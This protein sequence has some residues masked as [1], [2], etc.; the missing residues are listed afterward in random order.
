MFLICTVPVEHFQSHKELFVLPLFNFF[1]CFRILHS[2]S[3]YRSSDSEGHFDTPEEATPV[4]S[5]PDFSG[6]LENSSDPDR[7]GKWDRNPIHKYASSIK[8]LLSFVVNL[9]SK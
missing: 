6:E 7:T 2:L 9:K 1:G 4:R 8:H 3:G 5:I